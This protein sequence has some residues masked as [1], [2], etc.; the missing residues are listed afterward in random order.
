M[1]LVRVTGAAAVRDLS[2]QQLSDVL[3]A[4]IVL[5]CGACER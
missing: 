3:V 4:L 5:R 1:R 2:D